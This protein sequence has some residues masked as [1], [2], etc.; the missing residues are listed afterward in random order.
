MSV[1]DNFGLGKSAKIERNHGKLL[2]VQRHESI[3]ECAR[4]SQ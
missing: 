3:R 1:T 2:R 4:E